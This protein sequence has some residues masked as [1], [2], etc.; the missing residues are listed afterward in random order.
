LHN[1]TRLK[2]EDYVG[3]P[4]GAE[5]MRDLNDGVFLAEKP[6]RVMHNCL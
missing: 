3:I 4:N 6:Q 1:V 2:Y 5:A